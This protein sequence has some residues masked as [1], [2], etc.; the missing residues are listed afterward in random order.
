MKNYELTYLISEDFSEEEIK[1]FQ[2]K[3]NNLI[4]KEGGV[5]QKTNSSIK[6]NLGYSVKKKENAYLI[7]LNFC[8]EP[9]KLENLE[10]ELKS[11]SQILRYLILTK[12]KPFTGYGR[13]KVMP[14]TLERPSKKPT[15]PKV[16][17]KEIEKKLEEILEEY[18]PR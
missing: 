6:K 4:Q 12:P 17:L 10:K 9:G 8:L 5:L 13:T 15:K 16:E 18:E 7:S 14:E 3:I 1:T 11:E 2:E